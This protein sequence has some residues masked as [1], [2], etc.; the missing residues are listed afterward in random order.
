MEL[1]KLRA[2]KPQ[3]KGLGEVSARSDSF[4]LCSL[5]WE[6]EKTEEGVSINH[7]MVSFETA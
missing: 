3:Q 6:A 5:I 2:L 7:G 1:E 4:S